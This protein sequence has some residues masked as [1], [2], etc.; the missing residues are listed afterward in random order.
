MYN[1]CSKDRI[2][3]ANGF[4]REAPNVK[5]KSSFNFFDIDA[6][7]SVLEI[8]RTASYQVELSRLLKMAIL[9]THPDEL[10]RPHY[11]RDVITAYHG[12]L[13]DTVQRDLN[14]LSADWHAVGADMQ[15]SFARFANEADAT[16]LC[17]EKRWKNALKTRM[18]A[19][20]GTE[21]RAS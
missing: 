5:T 10:H 7:T 16:S 9:S 1:G 17:L 19:A 18:K 12:D 11:V 14:S 15:L 21:K 3:T 13:D 8:G 20:H 6:L 4:Q 2:Q